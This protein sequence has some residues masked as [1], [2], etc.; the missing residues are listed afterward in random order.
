MNL[1]QDQNEKTLLQIEVLGNCHSK[2]DLGTRQIQPQI[3][4]VAAYNW[5]PD[6][7]RDDGYRVPHLKEDA[8]FTIHNAQCIM[9]N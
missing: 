4:N 8:L 3:V 9:H 7:V 5:I 6:Q 2:L 1:I